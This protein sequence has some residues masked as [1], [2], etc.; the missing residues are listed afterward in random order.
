[1]VQKS[2][3]KRFE[4]YTFESVFFKSVEIE[5][6]V[7]SAHAHQQCSFQRY[8]IAFF[9]WLSPIIVIFMTAF[10]YSGQLEHLPCPSNIGLFE[11]F[12]T[13]MGYFICS[14]FLSKKITSRFSSLLKRVI[15]I[16]SSSCFTIFCSY[17]FQ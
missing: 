8:Y 6:V 14:V 7:V 16:A 2:F 17:Y 13:V 3:V 11:S 10:S 5:S 1:M 15:L 9:P 4:N 12:I